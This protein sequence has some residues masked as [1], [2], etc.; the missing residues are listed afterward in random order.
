M[1]RKS[2]EAL[3]KADQKQK[4]STD[5]SHDG[6]SQQESQYLTR[7]TRFRLSTEYELSICNCKHIL[8]MTIGERHSV[9]NPQRW[10]CN[11]CLTTESVW[12][13]LSCPN[14]ACGRYIHEHAL[15]HYLESGHPLVIDVNELYVYCYACEEYVLNDNKSGDIKVLRETLQAIRYQNFTGT[16]RSG[17]TLRTATISADEDVQMRRRLQQQQL[18]RDDRLFTAIWHSRFVRQRKTFRNWRNYVRNK[19]K[20]CQSDDEQASATVTLQRTSEIQEDFIGK[21]DN[22]LETLSES[23]ILPVATKLNSTST[24]APQTSVRD[25]KVESDKLLNDPA[26]KECIP[27]VSSSNISSSTVSSVD[28]VTEFKENLPQVQTEATNKMTETIK[29]DVI[30]LL[31][32][33][34]SVDTDLQ[35][36]IVLGSSVPSKEENTEQN[37]GQKDTVISDDAKITEPKVVEQPS[38]DN[39]SPKKRPSSEIV[40]V[41]SPRPKRANAA[42]RYKEIM[43]RLSQSLEPPRKKP[44]VA[45][46]ESAVDP[47]VNG[48]DSPVRRSLRLQ[49]REEATK[50]RQKQ[51]KKKKTSLSPNQK[52]RKARAAPVQKLSIPPRSRI[53]RR[54]TSESGT[55]SLY[56]SVPNRA[57]TSL[58][59]GVTGLRNL[60]NT[61]YL[62][63]II[64]VLGHLQKFR[65]CLLAVRDLEM[66][67]TTVCY[68]DPQVSP[69]S[70]LRVAGRRSTIEMYENQSTTASKKLLKMQ[71][72]LNGGHET[73]HKDDVDK[74]DVE[75][76]FGQKQ[77][78]TNSA[79]NPLSLC[80][81]L[82]DLYHIMWSGKWKLVSPYHF[83]SSVWQLIPSFRGYS[84]QDAQEFLCELLDK[85]VSEL[86]RRHVA[87]RNPSSR[88]SERISRVVHTVFEGQLHSKVRCLQCKHVSSRIEPF[89]DLSLEFPQRY[90]TSATNWK[91]HNK[92]CSLLEMLDKFTEAE[93]LDGG[94][95]YHCS[96]CNERQ[97]VGCSGHRTRVRRLSHRKVQNKLTEAEKQIKITELPQILRFHLKRFRWSGRNHREKITVPVDFPPE[98]DMTQHCWGPS[99]S[100]STMTPS[101]QEFM[102]DLSAVVIHHGRGFGSGHYT[103]YCWN[104]VGKFWVHCNDSNLELCSIDDVMQS[105]AYILFYT[106][107]GLD[108]HP[109][110]FSPTPTPDLSPPPSPSALFNGGDT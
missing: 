26:P 94:C 37:E 70:K 66:D 95:V 81:E 72:G 42:S 53:Y 109:H 51:N 20:H 1:G 13:C 64:Q 91:N 11:T 110:L 85:I 10:L 36:S 63:S 74:T 27:I 106:Q 6:V 100:S 33:Q 96:Y 5:L 48:V 49:I 60:G 29:T 39:K 84:Q 93:R 12:A 104:D 40:S 61:C 55:K 108:P 82:H 28:E 16:T 19:D 80:H 24:I 83:L 47:E 59:P 90:H 102:Y 17:H 101:G 62:N 4:R 21:L 44:C 103:A 87:P 18:D 32:D 73:G 78:C 45:E 43:T 46:K 92:S 77:F 54:V 98:L 99:E 30:I 34:L 56:D 69:S 97:Q 88:L 41:T 67:E 52:R 25:I 71:A 58:I 68:E 86:E 22:H 50:K 79:Q 107:R 89:W 3:M 31:T 14:V 57:V 8:R 75:T 7:C 76:L 2:P 15:N 9:V 65:R 35:K 23:K 38:I 105:Q